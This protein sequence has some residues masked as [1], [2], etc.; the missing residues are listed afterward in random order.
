MSLSPSDYLGS[1][2]YT[3]NIWMT[4]WLDTAVRR[5]FSSIHLVSYYWK[6]KKIRRKIRYMYIYIII[7][8]FI[9]QME[10]FIC[11]F[12]CLKLNNKLIIKSTQFGNSNKTKALQFSEDINESKNTKSERE[13]ENLALLNRWHRII[14]YN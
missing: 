2:F 8:K 4:W 1:F 10:T 3:A 12:M 13:R 9:I 7:I 11:I 6:K 5:I 14:R